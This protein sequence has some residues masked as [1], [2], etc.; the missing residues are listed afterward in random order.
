MHD[1]QLAY[2]AKK[3]DENGPQSRSDSF[4]SDKKSKELK[5]FYENKNESNQSFPYFEWKIAEKSNSD[6]SKVRKQFISFT[7]TTFLK[8]LNF[9]HIH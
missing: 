3:M 1:A 4:S 6:I 5:D 9:H 2:Y 7:Q 8:N